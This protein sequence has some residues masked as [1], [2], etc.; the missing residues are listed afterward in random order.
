MRL[1]IVFD[2]TIFK[3]DIG[4]KSGWGFSCLVETKKD[5]I[6]F[7]TGEDGNIL[8]KNMEILGLDPK[9]IS[10]IVISHEHYDHNGGLDSLL[11]I[12]DKAE[13][14]RVKNVKSSNNL[15]FIYSEKNMQIT[16]N[17]YTTGRLKGA[18]DEQSLILNGN[19][20]WY[21][22]VGCSHPGVGRIL[23]TAKSYGD[24]VGIIGGLHGFND[25]SL[26][27]N[28]DLIC[29]TH[30]T[31]HKKEIHRLFPETTIKGGVGQIINI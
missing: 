21:L 29:A 18:V 20:G 12:L 28:L 25:F 6:L 17:I 3:K 15:H 7:D 10:K 5:T 11:S 13:I 23:D 2:N 8:L 30:C 31:Q 16:E 1:T 27:N 22:L 9:K 26:F 4:L 24:I 19:N 14:Y